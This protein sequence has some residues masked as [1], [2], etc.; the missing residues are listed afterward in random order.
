MP[1]SRCSEHDLSRSEFALFSVDLKHP[2]PFDDKVDLVRS[3]V[4][5]RRL[6]LTRFEAV[7]IAEEPFGFEDPVLFHFFRRE[8]SDV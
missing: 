3:L 7:K 8:L 2:L 5:M 4:C 6:R 1:L